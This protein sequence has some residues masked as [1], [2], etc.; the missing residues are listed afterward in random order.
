MHWISNK[1]NQCPIN[2]GYLSNYEEYEVAMKLH[3]ENQSRMSQSEI[4][5]AQNI[6]MS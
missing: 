5:D 2:P 3:I 6:T 4:H 1:L